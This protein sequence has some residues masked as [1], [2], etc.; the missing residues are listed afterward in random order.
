[1]LC[2]ASLH[3]QNVDA[4]KLTGQKYDA[5]YMSNVKNM[6]FSMTMCVWQ[7]MVICPTQI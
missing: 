1:M 3:S 5:K 7:R 2:I 6:T 4:K